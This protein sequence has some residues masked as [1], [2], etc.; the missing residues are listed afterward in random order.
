MKP[1]ELPP[2]RRHPVPQTIGDYLLEVSRLLRDEAKHNT[3]ATHCTCIVCSAERLAQVGWP[4]AVTGDGR[5]GS[6]ELT[7]VEAAADADRPYADVADDLHKR[8]RVLY[9]AALMVH[10]TYTVIRRRG[11]DNEQVG[12]LG[13]CVCCEHFA[14]PKKNPTDRLRSGLCNACDIAWRRWR[15]ANPDGLRPDFI[16]SR[17]H[18]LQQTA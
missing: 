15:D 17:R 5:G 14:N 6:S 1:S 9:Q 7:I 4:S 13:T 12:G 8:L 16:R 11:N 10:E 18:Q 3:K 2:S